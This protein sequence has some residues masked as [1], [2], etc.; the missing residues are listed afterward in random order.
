MVRRRLRALLVA[1][2]FTLAGAAACG[3]PA[4]AAV[5]GGASCAPWSSKTLATTVG[6]IENLEFDRR[7]GLLFSFDHPT[8][9]SI[10]RL[11]RSGRITTLVPNVLG[12]GGQRMRGHVLYFNTGDLP[13]SG[14][15]GLK[16]GT[17]DTFDLRTRKRRTW[18]RSLV[19]PNGLVFLPNGDAVVSRDLNGPDGPT[20]ITRIR[21]SDPAHPQYNWVATDDS[22][23][24]AVDPTGTWLYFV[25]TNK[26]GSPLWRVRIASPRQSMLFAS[27]G[28]G[29]GLDDLTIDTE[30]V[31]YVTRN[32]YAG[33]G[34]VIRFDPRTRRSC[35]IAKGLSN[36]S[37]VKFG[38]GPGWPSDR[39]YVVAFDG[40]IRELSRPRGAP[41]SYGEC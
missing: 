32:D 29:S 27:L 40:T 18:A 26:D 4:G 8:D 15:A 5:P 21:R 1:V 19:M 41:P 37:S 23:G 33:A 24:M 31:L 17:I 11:D 38:C 10:K 13:W 16:D 30:G 34:E 12:P 14:W 22:N 20:G 35:A 39:L 2:A 6:I 28:P 7:G 25:Q 9:S 3:A 36:P